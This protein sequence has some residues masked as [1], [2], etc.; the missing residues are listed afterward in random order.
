MLVFPGRAAASWPKE[1]DLAVPGSAGTRILGSLAFSGIHALVGH[2]GGLAAADLNGD[3]VNGPILTAGTLSASPNRTSCGGA[4]ILF[5]KAA[6]PVIIEL[7]TTIA[8]PQADARIL[9]IDSS[10]NLGRARTILT[11]DCDGDWLKDLVL[12]ADVGDGPA[13]ARSGAGEAYLI[14]ARASW[15]AV[16]DLAAAGAVGTTIY[17]ATAGGLTGDRFT[18]QSNNHAAARLKLSR[19][20]TASSASPTIFPRRCHPHFSVRWFFQACHDSARFSAGGAHLFRSLE[21]DRMTVLL[22]IGIKKLEYGR[23]AR[24]ITHMKTTVE[25][26]D[27][28]LENIMGAMGFST[29]K[30]AIDWAL[31]EGERLA[32]MHSI[33][34]NPWS[35]EVLREA[36]DPDYDVLAARKTARYSKDGE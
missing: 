20:E 18:R 26:D 13:N 3:S 12:A 5:G 14:W 32:V 8:A 22:A 31:T 36:I 28:K 35:A 24:I 9:G 4:Y 27:T 15:P 29:R 33:R 19:S 10:D 23:M 2:N 17:G 1:I 6:W 16:L 34:A 21:L 7:E 25:L 30:E 11:G